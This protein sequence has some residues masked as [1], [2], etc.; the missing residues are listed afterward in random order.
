MTPLLLLLLLVL[1]SGVFQN[2]LLVL[3][4]YSIRNNY[5][6]INIYI[7]YRFLMLTMN[8]DE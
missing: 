3:K 4:I 5:I 8:F 6:H 7:I 2:S 1:P